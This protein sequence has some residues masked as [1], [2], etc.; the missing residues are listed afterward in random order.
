MHSPPTRRTPPRKSKPKPN[1]I[2]TPQ[3]HRIFD[4]WN[5]SSTGH[6]RAE[7][8]YS[9][10]PAWRDTRTAKLER[11]FSGGD[12]RER[13]R[14]DE[15]C[16]GAFDG[17]CGDELGEKGLDAGGRVGEWRW[18]AE[19]EA[20]RAQLGVRDIRSFMGVGKRKAELEEKPQTGKRVKGEKRD[21][22]AMVPRVSKSTPTPA[23]TSTAPPSTSTS[24]SISTSTPTL[25]SPFPSSLSPTTSPN[26][27]PGKTVSPQNS[28]THTHTIAPPP[29]PPQIFAGTTIYINGSTLPQ[30]SDHKLK[31]LLVSRGAAIAI[32]M[33]RKTVSHVIIGRPGSLGAGAGGGLAAG[34]WQGEIERG[35]WK[36][37][38]VVGVDWVLESIKAGKR[39]A[40]S[41]FVVL[42]I[43]PKGQRSVASML[44]AHGG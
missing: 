11:Q 37:V 32:G 18:V 27:R 26:P 13:A 33:A 3:N 24:T 41:R 30:I 20:K 38:R 10:T 6:Q 16:T 19:E 39:L 4:P 31:T 21:M 44:S 34:K 12:C 8:P 35:G 15:N 29:S 14:G 42:E 7:N 1:P 40:E 23:L 28:Q 25:P 5:S 9:S 17:T 22:L 43:A 2:P 36:G